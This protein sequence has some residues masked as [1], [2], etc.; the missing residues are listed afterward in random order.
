MALSEN[1]LK[2]RQEAPRTH[3]ISAFSDR[4]EAALTPVR[5]AYLSE[6]KNRLATD[7]GR[8]EYRVDLA[9]AL[10]TIVEMGFANLQEQAEAKQDIWKGGVISKL[11]IYVNALIRLL[12]NWPPDVEKPKDITNILKGDNG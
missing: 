4:G 2:Q 9:A 10:G 12:D 11:G 7:Q 1:E 8:A 5:N 6:L 3:G